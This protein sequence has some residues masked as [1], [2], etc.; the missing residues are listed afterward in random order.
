[1][2]REQHAK[3]LYFS[4]TESSSTLG[5]SQVERNFRIEKA[6][7]GAGGYGEW[8]C[9]NVVP[10]AQPFTAI[11]GHTSEAAGAFV[12]Q[13]LLEDFWP[14]WSSLSTVQSLFWDMGLSSC[15]SVFCGA[16]T[17]CVLVSWYLQWN[18]LGFLCWHCCQKGISLRPW[19]HL[20]FLKRE[21]RIT[22]ASWDLDLFLLLY[23]VLCSIQKLFSILQCWYYR[24]RLPSIIS[25]LMYLA[26]LHMFGNL[27]FNLQL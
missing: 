2:N 13:M 20:E 14:Q 6:G 21:S 8:I 23:S 25:C 3:C 19:K 11:W 22:S 10:S 4:W 7:R 27:P 9:S 17:D 24:K 16:K 18:S 15:V 12:E 1:M 5:F 26:P